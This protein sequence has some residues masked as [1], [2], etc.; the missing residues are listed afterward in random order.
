MRNTI[1]PEELTSRAT[2]TVLSFHVDVFKSWRN[3]ETGEITNEGILSFDCGHKYRWYPHG[4]TTNPRRG[5]RD[6]CAT[7]I[8]EILTEVTGLE[9]AN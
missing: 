6:M 1:T 9:G 7:C 2:H 4:A 8:N 5:D 3:I